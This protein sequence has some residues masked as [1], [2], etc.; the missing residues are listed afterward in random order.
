M[1]TFA[2]AAATIAPTPRMGVRVVNHSA[3]IAVDVVDVTAPSLETLPL[4]DDVEGFAPE[5]CESRPY[6]K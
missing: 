4:P 2:I 1:K 6:A 5:S 3:G